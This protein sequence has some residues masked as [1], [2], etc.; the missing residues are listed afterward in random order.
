MTANIQI[1]SLKLS[2]IWVE[3]FLNLLKNSLFQSELNFL[4]NYWAYIGRLDHLLKKNSGSGDLELPWSKPTGQNFWK[5]YLEMEPVRLTG[6]KAWRA[7]VPL[8]KQETSFKIDIP[9]L[10][11]QRPLLLETFFYPHGLAV[12]IT[13]S[14]KVK[15]DTPFTLREAVDTAFIIKQQKMFG[16]DETLPELL[17]LDEIAEKCLATH[18]NNLIGAELINTNRTITPFTILTFVEGNK[19]DD[20]ESPISELGEVHRALEAVTKWQP[21]WLY[22]SLDSLDKTR[23]NIRASPPSHILY[24]NRRGR[25]VWF[26]ALFMPQPIPCR[27]LGCFHRNLTLVSLQVESLGSLVSI[28]IRELEKGIPLVG[29]YR[30]CVKNTAGILGRLY[31]GVKSTYRS[32]SPRIQIEQ[33]QLVEDLNKLRDF[34]D[35]KPLS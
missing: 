8:R 15:K 13:V 29:D 20:L 26:P 27:T 25:A 1:Y 31:G 30:N 3:T 16:G 12:V 18:H 35:M 23:I 17:S 14:V 21:T 28:T 5:Y 10:P 7:L 19:I 34:F 6:N 2:I 11:G 22:D 33:N 32:W 4:G 24:G 9:S